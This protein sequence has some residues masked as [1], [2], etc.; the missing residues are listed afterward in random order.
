MK[1]WQFVW[2]NY[3]YFMRALS[4]YMARQMSKRNIKSMET[5]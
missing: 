5:T 3:V 1:L 2:G 4:T